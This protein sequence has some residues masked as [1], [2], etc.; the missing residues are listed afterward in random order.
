MKIV[1]EKHDLVSILEKHFEEKFDRSKIVVRADPF[2]VELCGIPLEAALPDG[3]AAPKAAVLTAVPKEPEAPTP[4]DDLHTKLALQDGA[5]LDAPT[6]GTD[7]VE[8]DDTR[9]ASPASLVARS[10]ALESELAKNRPPPKRQGG[11][12]A[13]PSDMKDE[14]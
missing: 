9:D 14:M 10:R 2:E 4:E 13:P 7:E 1:L 3:E 11:S 12:E 6:P 8:I 5:T